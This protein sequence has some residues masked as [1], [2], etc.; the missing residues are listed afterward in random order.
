MWGAGLSDVD[1]MA[2]SGCCLLTITVSLLHD[3]GCNRYWAGRDLAVPDGV[4]GHAW[5]LTSVSRMV[6]CMRGSNQP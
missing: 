5:P 3:R 2:Q 4:L 1:P 6:R